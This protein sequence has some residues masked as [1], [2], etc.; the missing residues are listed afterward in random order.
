M[1][2]VDEKLTYK[3]HPEDS[4]R[5]VFFLNWAANSGLFYKYYT[6]FSTGYVFAKSLF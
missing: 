6:Y 5:Y 4:E 1:I 2:S 3:P